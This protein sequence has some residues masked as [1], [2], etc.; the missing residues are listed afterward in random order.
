MPKGRDLLFDALEQQDIGFLFGNPGTT[1]LPLIDGCNEHPSVRYVMALHEDIAVGMAMGFARASGKV[2][3]VNLHVA[4]GLGHG[5]GNLYNAW[6]ARIPLLVTAGQQHTRLVI[7]EP[8]LTADL[9]AMAR[10]FTKWAYEVRFAEELPV[11]LQRAFKEALTA[12][13]GPVFLSLPADVMLADTEQCLPRM[14]AFGTAGRGDDSE[15]ARA[16]A[17]LSAAE[18]PLIV[19]GDG[20]G[21]SNAWPELVALAERLGAPVYTEAIPSVWNFPNRH[22]HWQGIMPDTASA[23][24]TIFDGVDVAVLCGYSSQ[25]PLAVYEGGGP[26]IPP[27]VKLVAVSDNAWEIGKNQPVE[28]GILGEVKLNLAALMS[29]VL[30]TSQ[31]RS[32][33]AAAARR[34]SALRERAA[35]R[36]ARWQQRVDQA[37]QQHALTATSVAAALAEVMPEDAIFCDETVSNRQPFVNLLGFTSPLSYWSGKGGGLGFSMPGA[38]GMKLAR[39]DRTVVNGIGDGSFLYYPQALW[40]AANLGLGSMVFLVLNNS[41][42]RVLK[43]GVQ[44]MGGPW[45][46]GG[47]YPP[48][49]DIEAPHVDVAATAR[50][51]G[52]TAEHIEHAADLRPA[53]ER[54]FGAGCPYLL[55]VAVEGSV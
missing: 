20:V 25:A 19:A 10:P 53:L 44:R 48:G 30:A 9:V 40:S 54:A 13:Q 21:L 42:Y 23:F 15:L 24:R 26:L 22:D 35:E 2:G 39:P 16:A 8:I 49:L 7:Q 17:L 45:A 27:G 14:R 4:P 46:S 29:A 1:E 5:L 31:P 6:R 41:S 52:V 36:H 51:M 3:V 43:I 28:A 37:R 12:P 18:N 50:A 33:V 38:L 47:A 32:A 34:R 11:A 55:D